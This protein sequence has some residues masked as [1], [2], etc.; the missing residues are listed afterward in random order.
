MKYM[1]SKRRIWKHI[2]P[3]VLEYKKK[4]S[5]Y[6]EPFCGGCNSL[7]QVNGIKRIAADINPYL[8]A[9]WKAL[10]MCEPML[11]PIDRELYNRVKRS[12]QEETDEFTDADKGWVG[13]MASFNGKFFNG[14]YSGEIVTATGVRRNYIHEAVNNIYEQL[15]DLLWT[16]F[17]CCEYDKLEIPRNS[18]IYCDPPTETQL[19]TIIAVLIMRSFTTG[20]LNKLSLVTRFIS[21]NIRCLMTALR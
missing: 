12:Y 10:M 8:I 7:S 4:A 5:C 2:A 20:L 3:I 15:P 13:F 19:H 14:G 9:M 11:W 16:K 1:G 17:Y 21:P 18:I 6:I